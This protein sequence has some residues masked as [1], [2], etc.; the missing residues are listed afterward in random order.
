[1]PIVEQP[2]ERPS[3]WT[4]P[5]YPPP[6]ITY[7]TY[8]RRFIGSCPPT[9]RLPEVPAGA[10]N[11]RSGIA[12]TSALKTASAIRWLTSAAQPD[13]GRGYFA[14]RKVPSG[15]ITRSGSNNP[16]RI[17]TSGNTCLIA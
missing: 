16:A 11:T 2:F 3:P 14:Y 6:D 13:T 5:P 9:D 4:E 7:I 1:M 10:A 17:G 8:E 15:S 12:F